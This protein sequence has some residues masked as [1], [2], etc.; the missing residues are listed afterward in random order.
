[1]K[2]IA[3]DVNSY[4]VIF[5][6]YPI[7][8]YTLP[9]AVYVFLESYD[10]S[11]KTIVPFCTHGGSRLSGTENVIKTLQPKASVLRGLEISRNVINRNPENGARK[12]IQ[13]W[14]A[15]LGYAQASS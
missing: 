9:R 1:L 15:S 3:L 11:G 6:G 14:L 5:I 12:P 7:W 4:D 13:D 2:P 8:W 10:F